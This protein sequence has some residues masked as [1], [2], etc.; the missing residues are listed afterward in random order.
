MALLG[1]SRP[2][3]MTGVP[4]SFTIMLGTDGGSRRCLERTDA[5]AA[6]AAWVKA[7]AMI[8]EASATMPK[9]FFIVILLLPKLQLGADVV[10]RPRD[11]VPAQEA[12]QESVLL[13]LQVVTG[14]EKRLQ[15]LIDF[16]REIDVYRSLRWCWPVVGHVIRVALELP[17]RADLLLLEVVRCLLRAEAKPLLNDFDQLP[18]R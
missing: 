18:G 10:A 5:C 15:Q 11:V 12:M 7:W 2:C 3:M 4:V 8:T 13:G 9:N 1:R 17:L 14:G 6:F 16:L